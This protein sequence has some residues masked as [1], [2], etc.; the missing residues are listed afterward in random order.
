MPDLTLVVVA[1]TDADLA[2]FQSAETDGIDLRL[3]VNHYGESLAGIANRELDASRR[4]VFGLC[5]ADTVFLAGSLAAFTDAAMAGA[6]CGLV[7]ATLDGSYHCCYAAGVDGPGPVSTLD[8]MGVFFRRDLGLRFD[9]ETFDGFHCH[10]EDLCLQA[11]A[12]GIPITVPAADAHHRNHNH[13]RAEWQ[14]QYQVYR[15]R[16]LAKWE[17]TEFRTT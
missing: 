5:H 6:V 10:V 17:G 14:A 3:M 4:A 13:A 1:A 11:A 15:Q 2:K 7:G 12:V 16:L 9:A 8:A